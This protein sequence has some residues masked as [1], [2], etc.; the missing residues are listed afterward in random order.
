[1]PKVQARGLRIHYQQLGAGP[2]LVLVHGLGANLAFWYLGV[3][4]LLATSHRVTAYDLRGHG[5]TGRTVSGY[6]TQALADDCLAVMDALSIGNAAVVGHS[7]GAA[8]AL[9]AAAAA[10]DRIDRVV[11]ADAYLPCFERPMTGRHDLR[12]RLARR[13]LRRR[14]VDVPPGLP[15]VAYGLLEELGSSRPGASV[16]TGGTGDTLAWMS[17]ER[18][19]D[20]WNRLRA[21]T[22]I[23]P[24][25]FDA[26]LS[27]ERLRALRPPV[28]AV[29]GTRSTVSS[30]SL[31]GVRGSVPDLRVVRV[32]EVGHLHPLVQP[33][34][35]AGHVQAFLAPAAQTEV[36]G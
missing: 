32:P 10:P 24:E 22:R 28:L 36:P 1:M 12:A 35:F 8:V 17:L 9:H 3:A 26:S 6:S 31:R 13:T 16:A 25:V 5:L 21:Q 7:Y 33:A 20:R 11:A 23:V 34:V 4:P 19:A 29:N 27:L 18:S 14:G 2:D 15:R 30:A